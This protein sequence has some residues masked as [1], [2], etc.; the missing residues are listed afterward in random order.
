[1]QKKVLLI[2]P[3]LY[4][5]PVWDPIRLSQP[6]GLWSIGTHLLKQGHEVRLLCAEMQ[7][8][9]NIQLLDSSGRLHDQSFAQFHAE[10][11]ADFKSVAAEQFQA[12]YAAH[13]GSYVRVGLD[14]SA[15]GAEVS[16]YAPELIGI[17]SCFTC[18]H[19]STI[20]LAQFLK[21]QFPE[22]WIVVG[23]QHATAWPDA[24]L[25]H[26]DGAIDFIVHGE[27]EKVFN[28]LVLCHGDKV[29][30]RSLAGVAWHESGETRVNPRPPFYT[31]DDYYDL[32]PSLLEG[33]GYTNARH[34]YPTEGRKFTDMLFSVGCHRACCYCFSPVMRGKL[35]SLQEENIRALLLK[36]KRYGYQELV[37]QDDDLLVG[38]NLNMLLRLF[39]EYGFRWQNNGGVEL[40]GL[41]DAKIDAI[42]ESRCR[43]IYVPFNPRS[44]QDRVPSLPEQKKLNL[45]RRM[46]DAG[47]YVI[48]SGIYGVPDLSHPD[49]F[50]DDMSRLSDTHIRLLKE[51]YCNASLVLPLSILPMT[52][53]WN[54]LERDGQKDFVFDREEWPDYSI[55]AP[56]IRPRQISKEKLEQRLISIHQNIDAEQ[57]SESWFS[58]FACNEQ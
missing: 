3:P 33:Q 36:L 58:A 25:S 24:L 8:V 22:A 31:L 17:S 12:K 21:K 52:Q 7:G 44:L 9:K 27:G 50:F 45:L 56:Q 47:I 20:D 51:G 49:H 13:A 5:H 14:F 30:A 43:C 16:R 32:E 10:K 37:L 4:R 57:V 39:A 48:T 42:I 2:N 54:V 26:A 53:W 41:D 6:L 40:E 35:R 28:D 15:I 55:F 38:D 29:K 11:V 1:M 46:R 19:Q 23:G 34:A 18:N